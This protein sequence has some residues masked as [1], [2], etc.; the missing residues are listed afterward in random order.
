MPL[1]IALFI[2]L[3][4]VEMVILIKVGGAIG[5]LNTVALVLLAAVV[6]AALLRRQGLAT[7]L[8]ANQRLESGEVPAQEML[9][10]VALAA[11]GA[12]LLTPGFVT[13]AVG[14]ALLLPPTRR[15][16]T[17]RLLKRLVAD[18][19]VYYRAGV[20]HRATDDMTDNE[21]RVIEGEYRREE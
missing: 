1:L 10:G 20:R 6:G 11:A 4:I 7:L 5:A 15:W 16:L 13:D 19:G 8:R 17:R 18:G 14:F 21:H 3:P 12:L 9:E 2:I